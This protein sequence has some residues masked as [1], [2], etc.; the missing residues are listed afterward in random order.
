MTISKA[1][2]NTRFFFALFYAHIGHMENNYVNVEHCRVSMSEVASVSL[3]QAWSRCGHT[4][5]MK[6]ME[7]VVAVMACDMSGQLSWPC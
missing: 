4:C 6:E 3:T 5:S 2:N 7:H 1:W